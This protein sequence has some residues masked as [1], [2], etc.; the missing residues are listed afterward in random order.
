MV[1]RGTNFRNAIVLHKRVAIAM[2]RL[3]TGNALRVVSKIFGVSSST[4]NELVLQFCKV[5]STLA[6]RFINFST[7][8]N[9]TLINILSFRN[10]VGCESLYFC[11]VFF[12][13]LTVFLLS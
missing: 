4:A 1:R 10:T 11:T 3:A 7:T 2:W 5:L 9:E 12:Y 6:S 8:V 13:N